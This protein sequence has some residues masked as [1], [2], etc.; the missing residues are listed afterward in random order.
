MLQGLWP[1]NIDA[2]LKIL[3][4]HSC[5]IMKAY[6]QEEVPDYHVLIRGIFLDPEE[7]IFGLIIWC[8]ECGSSRDTYTLNEVTLPFYPGDPKEKLCHMS[9]NT[10]F[11][12][13]L[14]VYQDDLVDVAQRAIDVVKT[15][16]YA[17]VK[18]TVTKTSQEK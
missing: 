12:L 14:V 5:C 16:Y 18:I 4:C 11:D 6:L 1:K 15:E 9:V 3:I 2:S 10:P 17:D 13:D 8:I 7:A